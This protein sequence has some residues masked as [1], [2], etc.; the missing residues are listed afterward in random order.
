MYELADDRLARAG[1]N[2]YE[3]SNWARAGH[4]SRHNNVYWNGAAWEAVGPGA[5]AFDGV[6]SR[7]WNAANLNAY[8]AALAVRQLPPG[9]QQTS[10]AAA[11][12][13]ERAILRLRTVAGLHYDV[14]QAPAFQSAVSWGVANGL[15]EQY[16]SADLEQDGSADNEGGVRLTR[17]GRLLSNEL[18]SRLLEPAQV[19]A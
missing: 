19:A 6:S 1:L 11:A 15:L 4:A 14:A 9:G 12:D 10:T 7:R 13:A 3:I 5:H 16:G 8:I 2:W 18:F 17:R